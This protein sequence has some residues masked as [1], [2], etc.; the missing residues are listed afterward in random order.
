M[1]SCPACG[2]ENPPA[3]RF[4]LSCGAPITDRARAT[5]ERRIVSIIFVDLVGFTGRAEQL[6]P[7]DVRALLG[8]Y[9][10]R[11]RREIESFGGTV[12]KFIG[13]AVMGVFGAPLAHGD[14]AQR[15]VRAALAVRDIAG[16]LV[17]GGLELR[18]AVN[19]GEAVVSLGARAALG[20]SLVAGDVVNTAARLQAAGPIDGVIVGAE[21]YLAT[22]DV[23]R[24]E[25][26]TPVVAKGKEQ[27]IPAWIAISAADVTGAPTD[28]DGIVGR[29]LELAIL[30]ALWDRVVAGRLPMLVSVVGPAGVGKTTLAAAFA[31]LAGESGARVV[32]GRSLPYRESG[33]YGALASQ[34]MTL[35]DVFESDAATLAASK[36][37][38]RTAQLL[39]GREA[40]ADA[41]ADDLAAVVGE[42]SGRV[43]LARDALFHSV[44]DFLEGAVRERPTILVFEDVHWAGASLLDL[45]LELAA[46]MR[47][48]PVCIL[49][50]ARPELFDARPEWG[51]GAPE[52]LGMTLGPLGEADA[53]ELV[54]RRIGDDERAEAVLKTAE[55]NPLFIAQLAASIGEIAPGRLPTNMREIVAARLD[56][57]PPAERAL[58][59]DAAVVG[60]A[61]WL[62]ALRALNESADDLSSSL[63]QLERRDLIRREASSI[64]EGKLQFGFT[65]ALIREVAYDMLSRAER[66]RRHAVVAEFF[67]RTS[68]GSSEAIG[69]LARHWLAAGDHERA[70]EQ[71]LRAAEVADR[72]WAKEH[73]VFLYR[74]ALGLIPAEDEDRRRAVRRRLGLA[75]AAALHAPD[76]RREGSPRE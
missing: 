53:R 26:S 76:V 62:D 21:T 61:F 43:A 57:L 64:F 67:E 8:P 2:Q 6:D 63:D 50:L 54:K 46:R 52:F 58:L 42:S 32:H 37:R 59:L 1:R 27:P 51:A 71:L 72:G 3:A 22:R 75:S 31:Q 48:V 66:A 12:E 5:D 49:T 24:Y 11:V 17:E 47:D 34:L 25:P 33:S 20:E 23:I 15:A 10:E 60:R 18:V 35:A 38:A 70:V 41:I 39:K 28:A 56:A 16:E 74:E 14:D 7:E 19:T 30:G 9:H 13:D 29:R 45:V 69:A 40:D 68:G 36:L 55:G 4:C 44:R 73:A 65:H